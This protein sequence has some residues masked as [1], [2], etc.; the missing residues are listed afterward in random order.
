MGFSEG[1]TEDRENSLETEQHCWGRKT[2]AL[3]KGNHPFPTRTMARWGRAANLGAEHRTRRWKEITKTR[4]S[5]VP[6]Q[7]LGPALRLLGRH[8][9]PRRTMSL[10]LPEISS[11]MK[12]SWLKLKLGKME[13]MLLGEKKRSDSGIS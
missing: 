1:S 13:V 4:G 8:N 11:S 5:C 10:C 6:G 9:R 2:A 12:S 3:E 7:L